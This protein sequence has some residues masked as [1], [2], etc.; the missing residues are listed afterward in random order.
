MLSEA[1][2]N[3][4]ANEE[5]LIHTG[6]VPIEMAIRMYV[7]KYAKTAKIKNIVDTFYHPFHWE[8]EYIKNI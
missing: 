8:F 2:A 6:I 7:Q 1:R 4:D 5:A 3:G